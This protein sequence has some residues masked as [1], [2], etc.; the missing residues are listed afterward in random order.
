V[1]SPSPRASRVA[2]SLLFFCNG[3]V[4]A[5]WGVHIPSIKDKF[6]LSEGALSLTML[7]MAFG[8]VL[9]MGRIGRLSAALGSARTCVWSGLLLAL[10]VALI[11]FMPSLPAL[12]VLLLIFGAVMAAL[13]VAMNAQAAIVESAYGRAVMSSMHGLFSLGGFAGA[14]LGALWRATEASTQ[15]HM[16]CVGLITAACCLAARPALR[17][18]PAHAEHASAHAK[19]Q[20]KRQLLQLGILAFLGLIAEGAMY[21]WSTV[22][23]RDYTQA[24]LAWINAGY[25]AFSIGMAGGRFTGDAIR[26]RLGNVRTLRWSAALCAAG[27]ALS[28]LWPAPIPA[29][30]GFGLIGLGTSN[31]MPVLFAAAANVPGMAASEAIA[32]MARIAYLGLLFGP[33]LIGALAQLLGLPLAL[34]LI[35]LS[36]AM[37]GLR[38]RAALAGSSD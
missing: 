1:K 14:A 29:A 25:A 7:A 4:F 18:D 30:L 36:A 21:D 6:Q 26:A 28:L 2:T 37:V 24:S 34:I 38:A 19:G 8:A 10:G 27:I 32:D 9:A 23:M 5:S 35:G 12:I 15:S 22:Y 3:F 16:L 11:L 33:V 13:D 17:G 20:A 31:M